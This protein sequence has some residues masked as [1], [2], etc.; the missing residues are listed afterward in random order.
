M[1]PDGAVNCDDDSTCTQ[2]DCSASSGCGHIGLSTS[3]DDADACIL[4]DICVD[5]S[6]VSGPLVDCDDGNVCTDN[7]C[8]A[9]AGCQTVPNAVVCDDGDACTSGDVCGASSCLGTAQI[10]CDDGSVCTQDACDSADGCVY[11][12]HDCDDGDP[13]TTDVC[14]PATGCGT[15]VDDGCDFDHDG[16]PL[17]DDTCP[18]IWNPDNL[19]TLCPAPGPGFDGS[20]PL[21][22]GSERA[23]Q[24]RRSYE[25]VEVPL[26][27][28]IPEVGVLGHYPLDDS[29]AGP[30]ATETARQFVGTVLDLV[31]SDVTLDTTSAGSFTLMARIRPDAIGTRQV[32][33]GA[34]TDSANANKT[35]TTFEVSA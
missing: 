8:D 16:V 11:A 7:R 32:V 1:P 19:A 13:W 23:S 3:C 27:S 10:D 24:W 2:D 33:I 18:G 12:P 21:N 9:L 5:S 35:T 28:G 34:A 17:S 31:Q 25:P 22:V 29:S 4:G 15:V 30:L 20:R 6:C 26:V 14:D